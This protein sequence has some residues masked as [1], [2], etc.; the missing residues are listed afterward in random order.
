MYYEVS[1]V[2]PIIVSDSTQPLA[3]VLWQESD[4][5]D[6][7]WEGIGIGTGDGLG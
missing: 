1:N 3:F 6:I 5:R 4:Q 7:V 2:R